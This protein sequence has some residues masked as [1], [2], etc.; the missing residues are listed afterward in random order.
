MKMTTAAPEVAI[1]EAAHAS[2]DTR[3]TTTGIAQEVRRLDREERLQK[4]GLQTEPLRY[5][6]STATVPRESRQTGD[7]QHTE[8]CLCDKR[9]PLSKYVLPGDVIETRDG[10]RLMAGRLFHDLT[11]EEV[12]ETLADSRALQTGARVRRL[13]A[14]IAKAEGDLRRLT[15]EIENAREILKSLG[16]R[17]NSLELERGEKEIA[18]ERAK[19]PL[20]EF[21]AGRSPE[22]RERALAEAART[23]RDAL[24]PAP[25]PERA[26]A[27]FA[28]REDGGKD[29]VWNSTTNQRERVR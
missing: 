16:Q 14:P 4:A 29:Y 20:E 19:T 5:C 23:D 9:L 10:D 15:G 28:P 21:F 12:D 18:I 26:K 7:A 25:P 17:I 3:P 27:H 1:T 24:P 2:A 11:V 6:E 8:E 13:Q 22:W